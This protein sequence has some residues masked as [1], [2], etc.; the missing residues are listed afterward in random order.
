MEIEELENVVNVKYW[1]PMYNCFYE[2]LPKYLVELIFYYQFENEI[3]MEMKI[4]KEE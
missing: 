4:R 1:T 3:E 2:S